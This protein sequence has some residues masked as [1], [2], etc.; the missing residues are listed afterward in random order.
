MNKVLYFVAFAVGAAAGSVATWQLTKKYYANLAQE[1]IDSVKEAFSNSK[2]EKENNT[3]TEPAETEE[4]IAEKEHVA[5]PLGNSLKPDIMEYASIIRKEGYTNYSNPTD[6]T[7]DD[8]NDDVQETPYVINPDDFAWNDEYEKVSLTYFADA[9]LVDE[10]DKPMEDVD[11][12]VGVDYV[13]HFGEYEDD[14]VYI[15][16][17]KL[18][19]D[20]EICRDLRTYES[21]LESNP[22]LRED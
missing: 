5:H 9:V 18:K 11:S 13:N 12:T 7:T 16:N 14:I 4:T 15:R 1:E 19:I 17:D 3:N 2:K 10:D 21:V 20:F 22:Y 6:A 8:E